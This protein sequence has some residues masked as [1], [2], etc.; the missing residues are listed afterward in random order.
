MHIIIFTNKMSLFVFLLFYLFMNTDLIF[1][2]TTGD[3]VAELNNVIHPIS[4]TPLSIGD[5]ELSVLDKFADV[6][7]L[8][9]GEATH[10]TRE[11]FQM[12]HR[13]LKYFVEK[14]GFKAIGFEADMGECIYIDRFICKGI[15]SISEAMSKMI[16]WTWKTDEVAELI[17]WM[18]D[19]NQNKPAESQ[20]HFFGFDCQSKKYVHN[21]V[22]E[23]N[24]QNNFPLNTTID[25]ILDEI[26]LLDVK[27]LASHNKTYTALYRAKCDTV[28]NYLEHNK[29]SLLGTNEEFEYQQ[30]IGLM[31]QTKQVIGII[32]SEDAMR[33]KYMA[34]NA[35]WFYN[36]LGE[37]A[38]I[39]LWAHNGHVSKFRSTTSSPN[40]M[41]YEL[42]KSFQQYYKVIAFSFN[43]GSFRAKGYVR[44]TDTYYDVSNFTITTA[45]PS[46]SSNY[47]F[48]FAESPDFILL[49][50]E[51]AASTTLYNWLN[52]NH[53]FLSIGASFE[54]QYFIY[55]FPQYNIGLLFD[56]VIHFHD[57]NA[58]IRF[59][60]SIIGVT[61]SPKILPLDLVLL[62]NYPNPFNPAT[63]IK[64]Y[65][66]KGSK[67]RVTIFDLIGREIAI[68]LDQQMNAGEHIVTWNGADFSSGVYF[69]RLAADNQI[70]TNKMLL[71]K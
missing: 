8:G 18:K 16:F 19:Y 28:I 11:F 48:S 65:L 2:Q 70:I 13:L 45:P 26:D 59:T 60:D 22:T 25:R 71:M 63:N 34:D 27:Y 55:T 41:G 30:M 33:N 4:N 32:Y 62:H 7:I 20:I 15:G 35:G 66:S 36:L 57:T 38:K 53:G 42:Q 43:Y 56:A 1:S 64:F 61:E 54:P 52:T 49:N 50:E 24:L 51:A 14:Y 21:L 39:M 17:L 12:K 58:S 40:A 23:Y 9:M 6:K 44:A 29:A 68:L 31:V 69:V 47:I 10:G 3:L 37:D 67:V 5:S 46:N